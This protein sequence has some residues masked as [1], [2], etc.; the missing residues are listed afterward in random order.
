MNFWLN[1]LLGLIF[2]NEIYSQGFCGRTNPQSAKD[3]IPYSNSTNL[4]CYLTSFNSPAE[5]SICINMKS[6][7]VFSIINVGN[8][9]YTVDCKGAPRY[10]E[11]F[12]FEDEYKP[13]GVNNPSAPADCSKN[14]TDPSACCLA[15]TTADFGENPLCYYYPRNYLKEVMNY[16]EVNKKGKSLYFACSSSQWGYS[17]MVL[18]IFLILI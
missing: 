11:L 6:S 7:D 8:M 12:P 1:G 16:T 13:C 15:S 18:F 9:Q 3:C 5:F 14:K 4:C 17:L 10:S 2:L